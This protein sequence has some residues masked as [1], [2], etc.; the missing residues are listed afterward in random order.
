MEGCASAHSGKGAS[1]PCRRRFRFTRRL[2]SFISTIA[3][4]SGHPLPYAQAVTKKAL[5][6]YGP[7]QSATSSPAAPARALTVAPPD[8]KAQAPAEEP[9]LSTIPFAVPLPPANPDHIVWECDTESRHGDLFLLSGDVEITFRN[10]RIHADSVQLNQETGEVVAQ[11]HLR[12]AGGDN[13]EYIQASHGTFNLRTGTGRFYDVSGS[14]G[15]RAVG[16]PATSA[17]GVRG[18]ESPNPFLFSG[19]MLDK[20]GPADYTIYDGTVTSCLLPRPDWLFSSHKLQ[21]E[22]GKAHAVNSTFHL[23]GLPVFFLPYVTAPMQPDQRQSGILIPVLGDSS[24][25]GITVGEQAYITLGRSADLTV[26]LVYYSLRGYAQSGT[27]RYRGLGEN[28]ITGHFSALQDRGYTANNGVYVN[29]GGEDLT[30][31]FRRQLSPNV[32][33]VG[34]GEYL[35]SYVYR[36]A[37]TDNFNQAISSDI[38]SIG[39][40]TRQT[41]G[42]SLDGR[43]ERYQGLKQVPLNGSAGAQVRILHVPSFDLYGTDRRI[44]GTPLLWTLDASV[45]GLKRVQPDFTSAGITERVDVRPELSLPVHFGG[46]S[47]LGSLA[48]RETFYSRSRLAPY[49]A[50][51]SPVELSQALNRADVEM[52]AEVRPPTLERSFAV[53]ERLQRFFGTEVRHTVEPEVTYRDVRG[54]DNFLGVL[55]FDEADL[56]SDTNQLEYGLTQHLYFRP[57]VRAAPHAPPGCPA[58][59]GSATL[60]A[61]GTGKPPEDKEPLP[62]TASPGDLPFEAAAQATQDGQEALPDALTPT[63]TDSTDANGIVTAA[64]SVP[65]VPLRT[66]SRHAAHCAPAAISAQESLVSWKLAQRYFFD[67]TFGGAVL[68]GRRDIFESTLSLS[69]IAFLTEPRNIS[70]LISR[71]RVRTSGHTDAEWD[72]DYDTGATKFTSS[73]VYFDA[74]EGPVFGGVSYARLNAPG[75]F[76]TEVFDSSSAASLVTSPLSNFSQL[77][78]LIGY[79]VPSKPGLAIGT[80]VGLDLNGGAVQYG[81]LQTSY[82]WN[83]CGLAVEYRKFNLGTVRNENAYR[84]NFTLANIGSAG[85]IRRAERLF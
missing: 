20:T 69:G 77:R 66:R 82:N 7:Y 12:V 52:Q 21:L 32:R 80:N 16:S 11:G 40:V 31:A 35:S 27:F 45:A 65:D 9:D 2:L 50:G 64:A 63:A 49:S 78:F 44:P 46:W 14:A 17:P 58:A 55:R 81:E 3:V 71:L 29:Q 51:A 10:R 25:K 30:A 6:A 79:G 48:S 74:H 22:G 23:L 70:P 54:V 56:V 43:V 73:N 85:N 28:F 39:Y 59:G 68:T 13:D 62:D 42:W 8:P 19:R 75:R 26:G 38:T 41:D 61:T 24:T 76:A 34:D 37:F 67:R 47:V 57:R 15:S 4:C 18:L 72:F 53:P 5:G 33:A 1:G 60:A 83:C 84:F 36:E